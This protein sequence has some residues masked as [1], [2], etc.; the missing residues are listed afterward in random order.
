[1]QEQGGN[2]DWNQWRDLKDLSRAYE[3]EKLF[4]KQKSRNQWLQGD[5]NTKFF[6]ASTT[7]RRRGNK[8]VSVVRLQGGLRES[9]EE[10]YKEVVL[11]QGS[12]YHLPPYKF[13]EN[14]SWNTLFD[15]QGNQ[16]QTRVEGGGQKSAVL[17]ESK[18]SSRSGW[19]DS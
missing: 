17:N 9:E 5:R 4:W 6:H 16:Q 2:R 11:L 3:Q 10:M 19:C 14:P 8:I 18:Q 15:N 7:Q 13:W 1:M 12:F